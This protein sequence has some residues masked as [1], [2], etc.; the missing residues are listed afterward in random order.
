MKILFP[1]IETTF[2]GVSQFARQDPTK[3]PP[4]DFSGHPRKRLP[5]GKSP[6]DNPKE[7]GEFYQFGMLEPR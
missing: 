1:F 7:L 3:T 5:D 6:S 4:F 2:L